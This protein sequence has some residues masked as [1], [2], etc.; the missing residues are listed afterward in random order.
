MP[1]H[2]LPRNDHILLTK[3]DDCQKQPQD[4]FCRIVVLK[5]WENYLGARLQLESLLKTDSSTDGFLFRIS[6]FSI[7]AGGYFSTAKELISDSFLIFIIA[8][9][10]IPMRIVW[11]KAIF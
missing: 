8:Q 7:S 3:Y 9:L 5:I 2:A 10:L 4:E 1:R 6:F 11:F